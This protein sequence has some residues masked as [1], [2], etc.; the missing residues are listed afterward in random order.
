MDEMKK[1]KFQKIE[2]DI[3]GRRIKQV[4]W[5]LEANRIGEIT[6]VIR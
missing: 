3:D 2:N 5:K 1:Q 6:D 4:C